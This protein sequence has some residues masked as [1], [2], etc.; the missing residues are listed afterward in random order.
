MP[1]KSAQKD[2]FRDE[3]EEI[4]LAA[5]VAARKKVAAYKRTKE[6]AKEAQRRAK[7]LRAMV[8]ALGAPPVD[9]S[10]TPG[11]RRAHAIEHGEWPW[12]VALQSRGMTPL[13]YAR[14]QVNPALGGESAKSW[15]KA[16]ARRS[17]WS[18]CWFR[19]SSPGR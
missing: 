16:G 10:G 15:L 18:A 17:F 1:K 11:F 5:Y 6:Q 7:N 2:S 19:S 12:R 13:D 8:D 14:R 4:A 3:L 9:G